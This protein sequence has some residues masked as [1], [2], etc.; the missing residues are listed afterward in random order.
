MSSLAAYAVEKRSAKQP[1]RFG[2]GAIEGVAGPETANNAAATSSFIPLLTLGIPAN[3]TMAV[4]FGALLL[5]DITPGPLMIT[6]HPDVFWGVIDSMYVGNLLL[7]ILSIPLIGLFVRILK[8]RPGILA[9]L[10]VLVTLIGVYTVRSNP[11][12]IVAVAVLG[13]FGYGMKKVGIPPGPLVLAFV[14]GGLLESSLRQSLRL[15]DGD[16]TRFFERPISATLLFAAVVV[17]G[18]GVPAV[19]ALRGRG[20]QP[21][22]PSSIASRRCACRR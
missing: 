8:V 16:P 17:L 15:F 21:V 11:F 20:P 14:L 12:D 7:L 18:I 5:Q 10:T 4:L 1:E 22:R 2:K 3:G 9:P 6:E 19:R 13:G